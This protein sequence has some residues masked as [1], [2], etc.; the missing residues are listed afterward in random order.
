MSD[1]LIELLSLEIPSHTPKELGFLEISGTAH[2]ENVN[3]RIYAYFLDQNANSKTAEIFLSA[4]KKLILE[5][6]EKHIPLGNYSCTTEVYTGEGRIDIVLRDDENQAAI[7]IENKIYH[8]LNNNLLDYWNHFKYPP[9]NKVGILLT[10]NINP[11]KQDLSNYF[12]NITHVEWIEAIKEI[13]LPSGLSLKNC[14]YLNDFFDTIERLTQNQSMTK[15]A[16]FYFNHTTQ[17]LKAKETIVAAERFLIDQMFEL[18]KKLDLNVYPNSYTG[19]FKNFWDEKNRRD[20]YYTVW[21][22]DLLKGKKSVYII[23]ELFREDVKKA[24]ALRALM[25]D[26]DHYKAMKKDGHSWTS[27]LHFAYMKYE[28]SMEEIRTLAET[29]FKKIETDFKPVMQ[30]IMRHNYSDLE[31]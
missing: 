30:K 21:L 8:H 20:T 6:T 23:I 1:E 14:V 11:V 27:G 26:D 15:E 9:E 10:L 4:L 19:N 28:L 2:L 3:S 24:D 16:E 18:G 31:L 13:G 12:I 17:M 29:L 25:Q 5:K 7:L 22:D